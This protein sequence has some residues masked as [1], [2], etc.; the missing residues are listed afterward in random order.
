MYSEEKTI[1][2][3]VVEN[4]FLTGNANDAQV[5]VKNLPKVSSTYIEQ[6]GEYSRSIML[7]ELRVGGR[8]IRAGY[9]SRSNT[10]YLSLMYD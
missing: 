4:Y 3:R 2:L 7:D 8:T 9:S 6:I 5:Q 10:V 1:I